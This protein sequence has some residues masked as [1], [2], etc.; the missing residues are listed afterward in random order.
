MLN[1]RYAFYVRFKLILQRQ[2][3]PRD[4]LT[5]LRIKDHG[6]YIHRYIYGVAVPFLLLWIMRLY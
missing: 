6:R 3:I 2:I 4:T 1:I 5:Y